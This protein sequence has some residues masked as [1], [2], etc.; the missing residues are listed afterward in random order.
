MDN[1]IEIE[2]NEDLTTKNL[3][4]MAIPFHTKFIL[5]YSEHSTLEMD[6]LGTVE[7]ITWD[8]NFRPDKHS[9]VNVDLDS[10]GFE[11]G[12]E[13]ALDSLKEFERA[14]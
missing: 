1:G 8:N 9:M 7:V 12:L 5:K 14:L 13:N 6:N 4:D 10:S 11:K 3:K 2:Y